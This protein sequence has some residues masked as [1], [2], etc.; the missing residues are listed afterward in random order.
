M[1]HNVLK[2]LSVGFVSFPAFVGLSLSLSV[3]LSLLLA[4]QVTGDQ[5]RNIIANNQRHATKSESS[6]SFLYIIS[7]AVH[8]FDNNFKRL[9]LSAER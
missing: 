4:L 5:Q 7:A 6:N 2:A 3:F 1:L 8:L 9:N